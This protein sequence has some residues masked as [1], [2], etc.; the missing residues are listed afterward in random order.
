M[1]EFA[2]RFN[3]EDLV[4]KEFKFW[5]LLLRPVPVIIGSCIILLK[6]KCLSLGDVTMYEM[7]E[8]PEVCH[9]FENGCKTLWGSE[10]QLSC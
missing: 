4:I 6:R 5:I 3:R 8:F 2:G 9:F 7:A 1:Y 10:V